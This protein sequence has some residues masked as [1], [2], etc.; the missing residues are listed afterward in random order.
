MTFAV[1]GAVGAVARA[2][3]V[4][5]AGGTTFRGDA[6]AA[7]TAGTEGE[8]MGVIVAGGCARTEGASLSIRGI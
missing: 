3:A 4:L 5:D 2:A 1:E 6:V 7:T 8:T